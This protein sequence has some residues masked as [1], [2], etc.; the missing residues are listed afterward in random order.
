ML[1]TKTDAFD[2]NIEEG[3]L[4]QSTVSMENAEITQ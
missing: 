1:L 3:T 2:E 4:E